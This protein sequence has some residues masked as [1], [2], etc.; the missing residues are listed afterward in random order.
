LGIYCDR[1]NFL[2][3]VASRIARRAVAAHQDVPPPPVVRSTTG[4]RATDLFRVPPDHLR[5]MTGH[6][7]SCCRRFALIRVLFCDPALHILG[8]RY[9]RRVAARCKVLTLAERRQMLGVVAVLSC[10]RHM[11][12]P[13]LGVGRELVASHECRRSNRSALPVVDL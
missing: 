7:C 9:C 13:S 12:G 2:I 8:Y 3:R 10:R 4:G 11:V 6:V 1:T 5:V